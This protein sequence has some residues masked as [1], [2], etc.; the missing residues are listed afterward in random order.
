MSDCLFLSTV[1]AKPP[2]KKPP[3]CAPC[4][5]ACRALDIRGMIGMGLGA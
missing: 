2:K 5:P 4:R 1:G 3:L